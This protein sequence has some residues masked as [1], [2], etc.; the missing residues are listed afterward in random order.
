MKEFR[1]RSLDLYTFKRF[2]HHFKTVFHES[3]L[4]FIN[5]K[6]YILDTIH[7]FWY[8]INSC[9]PVQECKNT[10]IIYII[11]DYQKENLSYVSSIPYKESTKASEPRPKGSS[12]AMTLDIINTSESNAPESS[13]LGVSEVSVEDEEF[14]FK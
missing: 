4:F 1:R 13:F 12:D 2:P 5:G 10:W 14:V 9:N 3:I 8:I 7:I 11:K 6:T